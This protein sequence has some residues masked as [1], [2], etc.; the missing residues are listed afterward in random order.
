M[1]TYGKG[2][3]SWSDL[4]NMPVYMRDFYFRE[5]NKAVEKERAVTQQLTQKPRK[6]GRT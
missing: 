2:G 5:M 3:W 4:Y 1:V 6:K